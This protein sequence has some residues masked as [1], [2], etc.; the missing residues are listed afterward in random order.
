MDRGHRN[1][2]VISHDICHVIQLAEFGGHGYSHIHKEVLPHMLKR[3]FSQTEVDQIMVE[4]PRRLLT[5]A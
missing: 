3:G 2:V 4:N 1:Q 5:I